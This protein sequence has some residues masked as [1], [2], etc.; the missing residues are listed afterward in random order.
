MA[1]FSWQQLRHTREPATLRLLVALALLSLGLILFLCTA[2]TPW[3][4]HITK[5]LASG[6]PL[7]LDDYITLGTWW[8]ALVALV[9]LLCA[10]AT[11]Q[12]WSLPA[13]PAL[14]STHAPRS[15]AVRQWVLLTTLAAV[16]LAGWARQPRLHHGLWNDELMHLRY[17]VWGDHDVSADGTLAFTPATIKDALFQ[18]KKGNNH[19]W[20]S[21][22]VRL[23]HWLGGGTWDG[24]KPFNAA[25]L[26]LFPFL[27]GLGTVALLCL[28]GGLLGSVRA[29]LA[30]GLILA[31]HPWHARWSVE[32]RGYSTMLLAITA[33]LYCLLRAL[34]DH[35]WRWWLGFAAC[36]AI[37]LLS[38]AGSVYV[39]A[40]IYLTT[41]TLLATRRSETG[42]RRLHAPLRLSVAG[43]ISLLPVA[44]I[45]G[46]SLPQITA[47]LAGTHHYDPL[48]AAW[49]RDLWSHLL[50][51]LPHTPGPDGNGGGMTLTDLASLHQLSP[52]LLYGLLPLTTL[53]GLAILLT[54]NWQTRL[55]S[56]TLTLAA[57]LAI[58]HNA[59]KGTAM[60]VWYLQ[61]LLPLFALSI[62][63][64]G[65]ALARRFPKATLLASAP[66]LLTMLYG[67]AT[68]PALERLRHIPRHTIKEAVT[69]CRG[70]APALHPS[71]STIT[72]T[73]GTG[74][75][76][77]ES[78]DPR[79]IELKTCAQLDTLI[80]QSE[81]TARPLHIYFADAHGLAQPR[82]GKGEDAEWPAL[83]TKI[84]TDPRLRKTG[85]FPAMEA[86]WSLTTYSLQPPGET[87]IRLRTTPTTPPPPLT[88]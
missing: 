57:L 82:K 34:S 28:L 24:Q 72:A 43:A 63:F 88:P 62:A 2:D 10:L 42:L 6:K 48:D 66:L 11:Q 16:L 47:Y 39:T 25:W 73:L 53:I 35:R 76:Q 7:K 17:Y 14:P 59:L 87:I 69:L 54:R 52:L 5:R 44:L 85:A 61:Y 33:A 12:W 20:S 58:A 56:L 36:Q 26:R 4:S 79:V 49:L 68:L 18:N 55:V 65:D 38:F 45:M 22:E 1:H 9:A 86:M 50:T 75:G 71:T 51:G 46:P 30:A 29:G 67:A 78:Y 41:L 64:A 19:I 23:G 40:A 31:I 70:H 80:L 60:L 8:G 84:Q 74:A 32:I 21:L 13:S 81:T 15:R 37:F 3:S 27:S 83:L 77:Y